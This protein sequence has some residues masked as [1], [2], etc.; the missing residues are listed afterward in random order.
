MKNL[1]KLVAISAAAVTLAGVGATTANAAIVVGGETYDPRN[2]QIENMSQ[3]DYI[4]FIQ[5][6]AGQINTKA[7][8][9]DALRTAIANAQSAYDAAEDAYND[10]VAERN[11]LRADLDAAIADRNAKQ[12]RV[13]ELAE[14]ARLVNRDYE[15]EKQTAAELLADKKAENEYTYNAVVRE[16]QDTT[17]AAENAVASAAQELQSAQD[18]VAAYQAAEETN[19]WTVDEKAAA[20]ARLEAALAA[21]GNADAAL[22]A[23]QAAETNGIANA[24]KQRDA[25]NVTATAEYNQTIRNIEAAYTN[26]QNIYN[27]AGIKGD[28]DAAHADA[29]K[30]AEAAEAKVAE[31]QKALATAEENVKTTLAAKDTAYAALRNAQR[32]YAALERHIS[33][34]ELALHQATV[35]GNINSNT[36][37]GEITKEEMDTIERV[38]GISSKE[39]EDQLADAEK[40]V[41]DLED[42]QEAGVPGAEGPDTDEEGNTVPGNNDSDN[43]SDDNGSD[44]NGSDD[45]G[46]DDNGSDD[47]NGG[48]NNGNGSNKGSGQAELPETGESSSYA[49]F[50]AAA[51]A[52]LAGVGLVAPSFKK[53]N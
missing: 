24:E 20:D 48:S 19:P 43:G 1:K 18:E 33:E 2:V 50:G 6:V 34:L 44:D 3:A 53:E 38:K 26:A 32:E 7:P 45:N 35:D 21:K 16:L 28:A 36:S 37:L 42:E 9:R 40:N 49:I 10:A 52:V 14:V 47:N 27:K 8:Q 13:D 30:A 29:E 4:A 41:K 25:A 15:G 39:L 22:S 11:E 17:T 51:L 31:L 5:D 46:S 23:A 12:A